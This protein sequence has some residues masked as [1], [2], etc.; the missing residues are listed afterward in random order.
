M[1]KKILITGLKEEENSGHLLLTMLEAFRLK[2]KK[3]GDL[4]EK[5]HM[6]G[7]EVKL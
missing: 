6:H 7:S 4:L 1:R 5:W 3:I 2:Q